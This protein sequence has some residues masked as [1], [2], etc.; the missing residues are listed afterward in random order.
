MEIKVSND[1][2]SMDVDALVVSMFEGEKT[3]QELVNTY[4]IE[5]DGFKG[6]KGQTYFL[7][8]Y[9]KIPAKKILVVGCGKRSEF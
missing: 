1:V 3:S 6:K 5:R 7:Q 9:D 8:T 4:A 2:K